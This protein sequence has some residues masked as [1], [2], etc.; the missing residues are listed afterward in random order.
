[1][2]GCSPRGEAGLLAL[3]V[4]LAVVW[5]CRRAHGRILMITHAHG[6]PGPPIS[7]YAPSPSG[8]WSHHPPT[9]LPTQP[10]SPLASLTHARTRTRTQRGERKTSQTDPPKNMPRNGITHRTQTTVGE[11]WP[12]V[13]RTLSRTKRGQS[14]PG[15]LRFGPFRCKTATRSSRCQRFCSWVRSWDNK[16]RRNLN[17]D[18]GIN[19]QKLIWHPG[20]VW[21]SFSIVP[22]IHCKHR[23]T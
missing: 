12:P 4:L 16:N 7:Q 2:W 23:K 6:P 14:V 17:Y 20:D 21:P 8:T 19:L 15:R 3:T 11:P 10:P 22:N 18:I 5:C 13:L 1:M 9:H